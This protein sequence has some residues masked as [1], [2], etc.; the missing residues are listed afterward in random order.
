MDAV[1]GYILT[2]A[3][4]AIIC[5]I[6]T[7]LVGEKGTGGTVVKMISGLFLM[8]TLIRPLEDIGAFGPSSLTDGLS[9]EASS[10]AAEGAQRTREALHDSIKQRCEAYI[11]DKA[12]SLD[13]SITVEV[14]LS[15]DDIP[16]PQSVVVKGRLSPFAKNELARTIEDDLGIPKEDQTWI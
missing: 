6:L 3:I 15:E 4:A 8:F 1:R 10:I 12:D 13:A 2:I 7:K 16:I 14:F 5:G 9:Q 11:L